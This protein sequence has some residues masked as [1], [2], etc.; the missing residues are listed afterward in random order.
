MMQKIKGKKEIKQA[1]WVLVD[2]LRKSYQRFL[3]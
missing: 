3:Y 1:Q 2:A